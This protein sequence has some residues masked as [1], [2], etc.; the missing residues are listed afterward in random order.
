MIINKKDAKTKPTIPKKDANIKNII[1]HNLIALT[2]ATLENI[3]LHIEEIAIIITIIGE[4]IP[5]LT[6]ASPKTIAPSILIAYQ[7]L[8]AFLSHFLLVFQK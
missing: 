4:T 6:A 5:A 7:I 3:K 1:F 2:I 8:M